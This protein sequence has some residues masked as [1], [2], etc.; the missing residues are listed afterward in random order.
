MTEP[1]RSPDSPAA[2]GGE[3]PPESFA[4]AGHDHAACRRTALANAEA[5]CRARGARLTAQRRRVLEL[6]WERHAPVGAYDLLARLSAEG[7]SRVAPPTVYRALDFL[8]AHGLIH[9]IESLNAYL[10]CPQP[11]VRHDGQFLI[12]RNCQAAAEMR[13]AAVDSALRAGARAHGFTV[14]TETVE[15]RGLCPAC[16]ATP[17]EGTRP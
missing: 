5:L 3:V 13:D 6:V 11:E 10:G 12:C 1:P 2:P 14:E 8:L 9:R 4:P 16:A 17:A 15:L 7:T